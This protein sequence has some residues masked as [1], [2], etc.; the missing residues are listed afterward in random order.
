MTNQ[1]NLLD[2]AVFFVDFLNELIWITGW[3]KVLGL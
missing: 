1:S 3:G 2:I